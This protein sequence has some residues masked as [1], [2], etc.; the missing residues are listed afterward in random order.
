MIFNVNQSMLSNKLYPDLIDSISALDKLEAL[1]KVYKQDYHGNQIVWRVWGFGS[2]AILLHG[3]SG[4]WNHWCKNIR[5]LTSL[6]RQVWIPDI[7]C[8]GDSDAPS[9]ILDI[10]HAS[11]ILLQGI[12]E[13]ISA[14]KFELIGFSMGSMG[15][16]YIA[17]KIP[18]RIRNLVLVSPPSLGISPKKSILTQDWTKELNEQ[19]R[20]QMIRNNLS[21]LMLWDERAINNLSFTIHKMNLLRDRMRKRKIYK[22][23]FLLEILKKIEIPFHCIIGSKDAL[24]H[25][26]LEMVVSTFN[27]LHTM[28]SIEIIQNSGH[29]VQF[30]KS[31]EFNTILENILF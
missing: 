18:S 27:H 7:P 12:D 13:F 5:T 17:K 1:S 10:D 20:D 3:G 31:T 23:D 26:N 2:P 4:A 22:T 8:F 29:W 11:D 28:K 19:S 6:G 30:E 9:G 21:S 15:A 25:G 24:Y 16:G 14:E